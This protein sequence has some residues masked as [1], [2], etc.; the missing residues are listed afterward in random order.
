MGPLP[1]IG[2]INLQPPITFQAAIGVS[3]DARGK[4]VVV[5]AA[6]TGAADVISILTYA[7]IRFIIDDRQRAL[8]SDIEIGNGSL[9]NTG[10]PKAE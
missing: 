4:P 9:R 10:F 6:E 1:S 7:L 5:H 8:T 2:D 3:I